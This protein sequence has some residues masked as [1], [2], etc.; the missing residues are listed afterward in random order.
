[1]IIILQLACIVALGL[2]L[3]RTWLGKP[4]YEDDGNWFYYAVFRDKG[5]RINFGVHSVPGHFGLHWVAL[6][7]S[8]VFDDD[9]PRFF[10]AAKAAWLTATSLAMY[11]TVFVFTGD[12]L[13][14]FLTALAFTLVWTTPNT[15]FMLT[16][17]EHFFLL[18]LLVALGAMRLGAVTDQLFWFAVAG[19]AVAW[20]TQFKITTTPVLAIMPLGLFWAQSPWWGL[21]VY[22]AAAAAQICL[23]LAVTPSRR[24]VGPPQNVLQMT[25]RS[26]FAYAAMVA[27]KY[28]ALG[29][30]KQFLWRLG[31][32]QRVNPYEYVSTVHRMHDGRTLAQKLEQVMHGVRDLSPLLVLAVAGVASLPWRFEPVVF[33]GLGFS[34]YFVL[35]QQ[36][37]GNYFTPHFSP[38]WVG[39]SIAAGVTAAQAIHQD[40]ANAGSLVAYVLMAGQLA[41]LAR[42]QV[43]ESKPWRKDAVGYCHADK[44][45]F[46]RVAQTVG[47]YVRDNSEENERLLVW[48]NHPAV[49]LYARRQTVGMKYL[50]TYGHSTVV[51]HEAHLFQALQETPPEWIVRYNNVVPES[52]N[53][54]N[55]SGRT[56]V[57]YDLVQ[58]IQIK[59]PK[60]R[61]ARSYTG[62]P[63]D[64]PIYRRNDAHYLRMLKERARAALDAD[65]AGACRVYLDRAL[66][67]APDD[68]EALLLAELAAAAPQDRRGL[69]EARVGVE[70]DP[71]AKGVALRLLAQQMRREGAVRPCLA[72]LTKAMPLVGEDPAAML[73]MGSLLV[74]M[75]EVAQGAQMLN[76]IMRI[77]PHSPLI[78]RALAEAL[79][80][81]GQPEDAAELR[82]RAQRLVDN[83]PVLARVLGEEPQGETEELAKM[84]SG[85]SIDGGEATAGASTASGSEEKSVE[86]P[87]S[88]G[89]D[90]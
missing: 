16:Y 70:K 7:L 44:A 25:Y 42:V 88:E 89:R 21:A 69:V 46:M 49:Y 23:P 50:F 82:R 3:S 22:G 76:E 81:L 20:S 26:L 6:Q 55:I 51:R 52:W 38:I 71:V 37:Q 39:V 14:A 84:S 43:R 1:M 75:G 59:D 47:E 32:V 41:W 58:R 29:P 60:G 17:A 68:I 67:L 4:Y 36:V 35:M 5:P 64:Y 8:R 30:L 79:V 11:W 40:G 86:S 66:A 77:Q 45:Y 74:E 53:I 62:M 28:P 73:L 19:G 9:S 15:L 65:D 72:T 61:V 12:M 2:G 54:E 33:A 13:S 24:E 56:G 27:G 83:D 57:R 80:P 85:S 31:N 90:A 87:E 18:P 78:M 48:G 34:A 10:Y 63:F